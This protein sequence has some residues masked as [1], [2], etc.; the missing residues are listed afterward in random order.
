MENEA[1]V[2]AVARV[3]AKVFDGL[4]ALVPEEPEADV[5][6]GR[7]ERRL[8]AEQ[9]GSRRRR[10][11]PEF[12]GG[13]KLVLHV[14]RVRRVRRAA[15]QQVEALPPK[16]RREA[17]RVGDAF[18][19]LLGA[20]R[21]APLL[22][23][24]RNL[25]PRLL[26]LR[27]E[28]RGALEERQAP[29][30]LGLVRRAED[31]HD[32]RGVERVD[33]HA[34]DRPVEQVMARLVEH[35]IPAREEAPP[36]RLGLD[37]ALRRRPAT[38]AQVVERHER[39]ERR[40]LGL[41]RRRRRRLLAGRR[42]R[43]G[44]GHGTGVV[45]VVGRVRRRAARAAEK[46][47]ASSRV[48]RRRALV[49]EAQAPARARLENPNGRVTGGDGEAG[50]VRGRRDPTGPGAG[51]GQRVEVRVELAPVRDGVAGRLGGHFR[52]RG[53]LPVVPAA[54]TVGAP[55][56]LEHAA[57]VGRDHEAERRQRAERHDGRGVD[58]E[59][60]NERESRRGVHAD[61]RRLVRRGQRDPRCRRGGRL[62]PARRAGHVGLGRVPFRPEDARHVE[63]VHV[64][65]LGGAV[66][67]RRR[68]P[69]AVERRRHVRDR[70]HVRMKVLDE[71]DA[72]LHLLP[73]LDV[74]VLRGRAHETGLGRHLCG[75]H[76]HFSRIF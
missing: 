19:G 13:R 64:V 12:V 56:A 33:A 73:E 67:A 30:A 65:Q 25:P 15:A 35:G 4:R 63:R 37:L 24:V 58:P 8:H 11:P 47:R 21:Q 3:R 76:R 45:R 27:V 20:H 22:R 62:E 48:E 34:D 72:P 5:A 69:E 31:G 74:P 2:V 52:H 70:A 7:P 10:A 43:G 42:R 54:R 60:G 66:V 9:G 1:V 46:P 26:H 36:A 61:W 17:R 40:V 16:R 51:L 71:F 44:L 57:R 50:P 6:H 23:R 59:L 53:A 18:A 55:P 68:Q 49:E 14:A 39:A 28:L 38:V 75:H 29:E 32:P 41:R